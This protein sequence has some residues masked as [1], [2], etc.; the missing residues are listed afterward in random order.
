[1]TKNSVLHL[2]RELRFGLHEQ[3]HRLT[4]SASNGFAGNPALLGN[5]IA[6]FLT[7]TATLSGAVDPRTGMLIN[8]KIVDRVL[9]DHAVPMVRRACYDNGQPPAALVC[10]LMSGLGERFAPYVLERLSLGVSPYLHF[11]ISKQEAGMVSVSQRFEFSA[12]HRLHSETLS[13]EE[14]REVFGRCNNPNGHGH[15]YELE[16]TVAGPVGADGQV[17]PIETLQQ[18]VNEQVVEV[19]DHKHLNVDCPEF[20]GLNP[21]VENIA[22]VIYEKLAGAV[23]GPARVARIRVWETPKTF[24]EISE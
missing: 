7:L 9:R 5:G 14:N 22:A 15:N 8:I 16:V 1:M 6:P 3:E 24:C 21:T 13:A 18:L 4:A 12:A 17:M 20:A 2:T 23:E 19:F 11:A 10:E